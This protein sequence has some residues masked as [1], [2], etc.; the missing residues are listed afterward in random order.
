MNNSSDNDNNLTWPIKAYKNFEFL[1]SPDARTVRVLCEFIEPA[2]RFRHLRVRNTIVFFGSTRITTREAA[3][4]NLRQIEKE[5][6]SGAGPQG[7]L[8]GKFEQARRSLTMSRY[9]EEAVLLAEK[10]TQWSLSIE[11]P[12]KRFYICSG[13]GPGIME[14]ANR[15]AQ[16]AGGPSIG[17]NISLPFEQTP[18]P[19][20]TKELS[21]E[22]HYFFVRKYWFFYL[23]KALVIFP[24]GFGTMDEMF[25][26]LTI[27][28]TEKTKK[29]MPIILYGTEYWHEIINF[30]AL[31]KWGTISEEDLNLFHF[32]DDVDSAFEFL[33]D[34]LAHLYVPE[35]PEHDNI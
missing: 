14:A 1:N 31:V 26:L 24:G 15:G 2:A 17:L 33:R 5:C 34:E 12:A 30:N 27:V 7:M 29:Y 19:F 3:E 11:D 20:Q 6:S 13:G 28:Q 21:F 16:Q 9:Y 32:F 35:Q 10:L 23:G 22:F 4:K 8:T 18:N 25:E